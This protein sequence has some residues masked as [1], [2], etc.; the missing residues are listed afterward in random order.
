MV[1]EK[2]ACRFTRVCHISR[3]AHTLLQLLHILQELQSLSQ[4]VVDT[5]VSE[6]ISNQVMD[7]NIKIDADLLKSFSVSRASSP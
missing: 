4:H 6:D 2:V 7:W 3:Y 5:T 1:E